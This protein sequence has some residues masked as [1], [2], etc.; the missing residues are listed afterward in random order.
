MPGIFPSRPCP[1]PRGSAFAGH[2]DPSDTGSEDLIVIRSSKIHLE[3][4][5]ETYLEH[6]QAALAIA[7]KLALASGAC[8][9][10][11]LVPGLCTKTASRTV[12]ELN[13]TLKR[14]SGAFRPLATYFEPPSRTSVPPTVAPQSAEIE[15][16]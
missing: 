16:L 14:R 10:H 3:Q 6:L 11:A 5:H 7:S 1:T 2:H 4:A 8:A 15:R 13:G 12:T 9:L